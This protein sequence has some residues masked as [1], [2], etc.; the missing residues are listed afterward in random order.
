MQAASRGACALALVLLAVTAARASGAVATL[1]PT[2]YELDLRPDFESGLLNGAADITFCNPSEAPLDEVV[3]LLYRM[4]PVSGASDEARR[5]L[6]VAQAVVSFEDFPPLQV[7]RVLVGLVDPVAPGESATLSIEY[8]GHLRGYTETGM[9][10]MKDAIDRD[11]AILRNDAFAFPIVCGASVAE[12]RTSVENTFTYEARVTV[13]DDLVVVNGGR[14]VSVDAAGEGLTAYTCASIE[15]SWRMD[16]V[17]GAY[18][19]LERGPV[20]VSFLPGD[21]EGA[22]RVADAARANELIERLSA[23]LADGPGW[24]D[25]PFVE[26]GTTGLTDL[27]YT[28]GGL[29]FDLLY[30]VAGRDAFNRIVGDYLAEYGDEGGTTDDFARVARERCPGG[31]DELFSEWVYTTRWTERVT[32][33]ENVKELASVYR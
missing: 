21:E 9:R 12:M 32:A 23:G 5:D 3:F 1:V 13:P 18:E 33:A 24:A 10:Y 17:I 20:R 2:H 27:S 16:F 4:M 22:S 15:P 14:F 7:N 8:G 28:V 29:F 11:F 30:R 19:T 26:Y 31:V 25:V 6:E